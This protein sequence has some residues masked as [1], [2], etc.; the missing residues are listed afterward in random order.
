MQ[1]AHLVSA[2]YNSASAALPESKLI[3]RDT[4]GQVNSSVI[5][6][7]NVLGVGDRYQTEACIAT[8]AGLLHTSIVLPRIKCSYQKR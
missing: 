3:T 5:F 8:L 4:R 2:D 1:H 7:P 6:M